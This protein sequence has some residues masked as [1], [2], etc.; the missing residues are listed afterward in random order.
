MVRGAF[1]DCE[2]R[3][4]RHHH[5]AIGLS[6][7]L[8]VAVI[9]AYVSGASHC[10][11]L[12]AVLAER[13]TLLG[14]T[15]QHA[16]LTAL[17]FVVLYVAVAAAAIPGAAV[18]SLLGG[19]LFGRWLG[20]AL[21]VI[22]ATL[23][24]AIVFSI[25]RSALGEPLR[26]RA[27]P[28]YDKISAGVTAHPIEVL[29]FLRFMPLFPFFLV[30]PAAA[31]FDLRLTTFLV[32]TAIGIAPAAFIYNSL[33]REIGTVSSLSGLLSPGALVALFG[34]AGLSL[35]PILLRSWRPWARS[36]APHGEDRG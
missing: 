17:G 29:L 13:Q 23:G 3:L 9:A 8:I 15:V 32:T 6:A 10:L 19:F 30:N 12:Q 22:G 21:V 31:L 33:G 11:S 16:G 18:L 5:I 35:L 7:F 26:R 34:L 27:G 25:A 2:I 28:L 24:A 14:W 36:S 4:S 20:T 1:V